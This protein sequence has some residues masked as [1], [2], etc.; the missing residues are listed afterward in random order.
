LKQ[1]DEAASGNDCLSGDRSCRE[2]NSTYLKSLERT[3]LKSPE[4]PV[5]TKE[6]EVAFGES[7]AVSKEQ[8]RVELVPPRPPREDR[9]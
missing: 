5:G 8:R 1:R 2:S 6:E 3:Y 4:R 7:A 9:L